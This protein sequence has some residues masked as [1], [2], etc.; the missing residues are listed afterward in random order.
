MGVDRCE[1]AEDALESTDDLL[2]KYSS[3]RLR[4]P[5]RPPAMAVLIE[6][7]TSNATTNS[8]NAQ[9][10]NSLLKTLNV[11][12]KTNGFVKMDLQK[13]AQEASLSGLV[14]AVPIETIRAVLNS[15]MRAKFGL[16]DIGFMILNPER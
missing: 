14:M 8:S 5:E 3:I 15:R 12:S 1:K 13:R 2:C 11:D 16:R 9:L 7:N 10:L 6:T 4:S